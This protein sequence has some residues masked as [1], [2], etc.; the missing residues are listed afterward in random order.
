VDD[1]VAADVVV[2]WE[3]LKMPPFT[4]EEEGDVTT[5]VG[6]LPSL[7]GVA[8]SPSCVVVLVLAAA[9]APSGVGSFAV[10]VVVGF[11][12]GDAAVGKGLS[13]AG[14]FTGCGFADGASGAGAF[15]DGACGLGAAGAD[16]DIT[17]VGVG[18]TLL[19]V[20]T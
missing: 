15:T 6:E 2:V 10:G 3:P 19:V 18:A 20:G 12:C 17:G 9:A 1:L 11:A 13:E 5:A 8:L 4:S 14:V 7:D 16:E